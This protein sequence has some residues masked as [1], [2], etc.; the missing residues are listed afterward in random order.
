MGKQL[1]WKREFDSQFPRG[2]RKCA[3]THREALG[4]LG[5]RERRGEM[6]ARAFIAFSMEKARQG[7]Q[8]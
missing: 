2:E 6:R 4:S 8:A 5:G 3:M 1:I 7:E